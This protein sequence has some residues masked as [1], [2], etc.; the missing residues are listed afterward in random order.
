MV[1]DTEAQP[2]P[3]W[4]GDAQDA[5]YSPGPLG[6][7]GFLLK[8]HTRGQEWRWEQS[9]AILTNSFLLLYTLDNRSSAKDSGCFQTVKGKQRF[10]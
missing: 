4:A 2:Q 5:Q 10:L 6:T 1:R 7:L 8:N 9:A 3:M